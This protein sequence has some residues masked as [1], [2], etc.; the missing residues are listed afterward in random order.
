MA[1]SFTHDLR[2]KLFIICP[3]SI[4]P[5][6]IRI[7]NELE[8]TKSNPI[9]FPIKPP[10]SFS[11]KPEIL[12]GKY[13]IKLKSTLVQTQ[14]PEIKVKAISFQSKHR[15]G[16]PGCYSYIVC[17]NT[18]HKEDIEPSQTKCACGNDR[19]ECLCYVTY[20]YDCHGIRYEDGRFLIAPFGILA[21]NEK[22]EVGPCLCN[23]NEISL[24]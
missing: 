14:N 6:W 2:K 1:Y 15:D 18:Y 20:G 9:E 3:K 5:E 21:K 24:I 17:E 19:I 11:K 16:S 12:A 23:N 13:Q 10:R 4:L 8:P 7:A 22:Y